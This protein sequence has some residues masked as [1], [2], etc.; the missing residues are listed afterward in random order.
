MKTARL[1]PPAT[2]A[3]ALARQ[4]AEH[5]AFWAKLKTGAALAMI[6]APAFAH[7]GHLFHHH[8]AEIAPLALI[9]GALALAAI[10]QQIAKVIK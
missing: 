6:S 2:P 4:R 9:L 7:P 3:E 1:A 8:A 5:N 10:V